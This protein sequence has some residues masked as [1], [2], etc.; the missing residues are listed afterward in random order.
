MNPHRY[1]RRLAFIVPDAHLTALT[2]RCPGASVWANRNSEASIEGFGEP[3]PIEMCPAE[4]SIL[5][6]DPLQVG[7]PN[8]ESGEVQTTQIAAQFLEQANHAGRAIALRHG[9]RRAKPVE[10]TQE[11]L[12]D[13]RIVTEFDTQSL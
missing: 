8:G 9:I 12:F 11:L 10:L 3:H 13:T 2:A 6:L 5:H 7:S 1:I 4:R